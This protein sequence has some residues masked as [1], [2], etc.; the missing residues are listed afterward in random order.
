VTAG[1]P[2]VSPQATGDEDAGEPLYRRVINIFGGD[3]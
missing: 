2:W 3:G 1:L